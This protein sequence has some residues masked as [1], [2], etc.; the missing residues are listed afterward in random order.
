LVNTPSTSNT[1]QVIFSK[2]VSKGIIF[3]GYHA[4]HIPKHFESSPN[5]LR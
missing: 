1:K 3:F 2:A 4:I 5:D